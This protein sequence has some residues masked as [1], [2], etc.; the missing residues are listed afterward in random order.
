ME[1]RTH[2]PQLSRLVETCYGEHSYL[3][4]GYKVLS[5]EARVQQGNHLGSLLFAL[6][7]QPVAQQ[8]QEVEGLHLNAWYQDDRTL[9]GSREAL[10]EAWDLLVA[11][12]H[13][14]GLHLSLV[15]SLVA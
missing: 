13:P 11:E 2:Y 5:S 1:V 6:L 9:V 3:N 10:Q 7:L 4:L 8:P 12:G 15:K 14:R